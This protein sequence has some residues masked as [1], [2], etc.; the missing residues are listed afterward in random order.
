M[1]ATTGVRDLREW[2]NRQRAR[3]PQPAENVPCA[4]AWVPT[5][6]C[7]WAVSLPFTWTPELPLTVL[8]RVATSAQRGQPGTGRRLRCPTGRTLSDPS[9]PSAPLPSAPPAGRGSS[10]RAPSTSRRSSATTFTITGSYLGFIRA[11]NVDQCWEGN[12]FG[13][14]DI[15]YTTAKHVCS[16]LTL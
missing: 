13:V 15:I 5:C 9:A 11:A 10:S 2:R 8:C 12:S 4:G 3:A 7:G 1:D 14:L 6:P 16:P